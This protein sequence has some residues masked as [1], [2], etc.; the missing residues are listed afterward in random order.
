MRQKEYTG[1]KIQYASDLH[2]EFAEN[3]RYLRENPLA[4]T[5]DVLVLAGDIGYLGDKVSNK[6]PFWSWA[7]DN[8]EQVIAIPGNHE[9]YGGFDI[10]NVH[11]GWSYAIRS[12]VHYHYNAVI[13][14]GDTDLVL[15][16]LWGQ[17]DFL[18]AV[19]TMRRVNDF[20]YIRCEQKTWDWIRFN[21]EHFRCFH[22]L[23]GCI[24]RSKAK[25]IIVVSHHV[26]AAA[27]M[28]PEFQDSDL[29]GAFMVNLADY[30][31]ASPIEYW[32]YGHSH[33]N[34]CKTV[35]NT[36]CVSNQLGYV[37]GRE[38]GTFSLSRNIEI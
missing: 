38:H 23:N 8:Y 28:A 24:E 22:F 37:A 25:H 6:H 14:L 18:K 16:T 13:S 15:T 5:G 27:L 12:N 2:L 1:I 36:V 7:A 4:V 19:E 29:N 11:D 9:F 31:K 3:T 34:I 26:P 33:R 10:D 21:E 30:I 35:G 32:I 20:R 17:I